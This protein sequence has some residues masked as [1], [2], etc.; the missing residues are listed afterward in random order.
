MLL[1]MLRL[2]YDIYYFSNYFI[3]YLKSIVFILIL[4]KSFFSIIYIFKNNNLLPK[5]YNTY[6]NFSIMSNIAL[7]FGKRTMRVS[8]HGIITHLINLCHV[9]LE[10]FGKL[11]MS[12]HTG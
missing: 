10:L 1:E 9:L 11:A 3:I 5:T 7:I 12:A 2:I 6:A 4:F 8:H